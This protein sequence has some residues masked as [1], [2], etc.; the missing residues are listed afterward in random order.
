[1]VETNELLSKIL[2]WDFSDNLE[3]ETEG[4]G[5]DVQIYGQLKNYF[6]ELFLHFTCIPVY[7]NSLKI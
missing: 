6:E 5:V 3:Y 2:N 7:Q 4:D 1:M